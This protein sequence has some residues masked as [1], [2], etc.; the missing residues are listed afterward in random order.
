MN[1]PV[2]HP[3]HYTSHPSGLECIVFSRHM[4]FALG[5]A[6]KYLWRAGIKDPAKERE[7][8][9]KALWYLNDFLN[10]YPEDVE[11]PAIPPAVQSDWHKFVIPV[12]KSNDPVFLVQ[13]H[14][15][16]LHV[17]RDKDEAWKAWIKL[18]A[19]IRHLE[20]EHG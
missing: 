18:D 13:Q 2:N 3:K 19:Y 4:G 9:R 20:S 10:G 12:S 8:L 1:D 17:T 6:F 14:V 11:T 16:E 15:Y 7:D 5:N